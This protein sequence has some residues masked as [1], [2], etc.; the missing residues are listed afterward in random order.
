MSRRRWL[1]S[2]APGVTDDSF[3]PG[4]NNGL[5]HCG[6][7][8]FYYGRMCDKSCLV[9]G[10]AAPIPTAV[11]RRLNQTPHFFDRSPQSTLPVRSML[12]VRASWD[13]GHGHCFAAA[14]ALQPCD[15]REN[16]PNYVCH[17]PRS[18]MT[19]DTIMTICFSFALSPRL[20]QRVGELDK[21]RLAERQAWRV[22]RKQQLQCEAKRPRH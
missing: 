20:A 15:K 22:S 9:P 8:T 12:Y 11:S 3:G 1:Q 14:A 19:M 13:M 10:L 7:T 6:W 17:G 16:L 18:I 4:R 2:C 5:R 21:K